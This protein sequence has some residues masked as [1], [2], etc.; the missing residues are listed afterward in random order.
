MFLFLDFDGVLNCNQGGLSPRHV[1]GLEHIC[2]TLPAV[3]VVT[4]TS[5]NYFPLNVLWKKLQ[6]AGFEQAPKFLV[7]KTETCRGG[8]EPILDW[9]AHNDIMGEPYAILDDSVQPYRLLWSRLVAVDGTVGLTHSNVARVYS[10]LRET[11]FSAEEEKKRAGLHIVENVIRLHDR[12]TWLSRAQRD[13]AARMQMGVLS[14]LL[15]NS[16]LLED[17]RLVPRASAG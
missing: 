10:L 2:L 1:K 9:M 11:S 5:W 13:H 14:D 8:E 6:E 17:L 12:A 15:G 16:E 3:K 4:N 7:S